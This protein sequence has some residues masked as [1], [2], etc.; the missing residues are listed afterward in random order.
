QRRIRLIDVINDESDTTDADIVERR[1][2]LALRRRIDELHEVEHRG[3]GIIAQAHEHAPQF[4][5]FEAERLP[6]PGRPA[7]ENKVV[8][9]RKAEVLV[10]LD[11]PLHIADTNIDVKESAKHA[12]PRLTAD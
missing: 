12:C 6:Y 4:L 11:R 7:T 10:E 9:L 3:I 8:G 5:H 1:V 2:R